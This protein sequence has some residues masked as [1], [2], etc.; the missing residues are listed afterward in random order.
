MSV[1]YRINHRRCQPEHNNYPNIQISKEALKYLRHQMNILKIPFIN[2]LKI[3][4][5]KNLSL[6]KEPHTLNH[7]DTIHAGAIFTLAETASGNTLKKSF[8]EYENKVIPILRDSNIKYK[9]PA[10]SDIYADASITDEAIEKFITQ[11]EKKS[12]ATIEVNVIVRDIE[13]NTIA[14]ALFT[15]FVQKID[16]V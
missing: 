3:T 14:T 12:R 11:F 15:W 7:I 1:P 16:D 2:H 8:P 10:L 9:K 5:D 13:D 4:Q 6:K